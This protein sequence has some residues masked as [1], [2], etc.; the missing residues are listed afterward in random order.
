M[1]KTGLWEKQGIHV[2][3]LAV[4]SGHLVHDDIHCA[5]VYYNHIHDACV[6]YSYIHV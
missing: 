5:G 4:L 6:Y 1:G 3:K 2:Q